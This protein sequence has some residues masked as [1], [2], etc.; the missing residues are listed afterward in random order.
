MVLNIMLNK[1]IRN[2]ITVHEEIFEAIAAHPKA[3]NTEIAKIVFNTKVGSNYSL[4]SLKNYVGK[5]RKAAKENIP[6]PTI[7]DFKY[8]HTISGKQNAVL[9]FADFP[10]ISKSALSTMLINKG[11]FTYGTANN[12]ASAVLKNPPKPKS[13]TKT[14]EKV[15]MVGGSPFTATQVINEAK[16]KT[17]TKKQSVNLLTEVIIIPKSQLSF[18]DA[19]F[20]DISRN[21]N[22][23]DTVIICVTD[24]RNEILWNGPRSGLALSRQYTN[25]NRYRKS[26]TT[27]ICWADAIS[28]CIYLASGVN[29][30]FTNIHC[31][32]ENLD[33]KSEISSKDLREAVNMYRDELSWIFSATTLGV[34]TMGKDQI[35][36]LIDSGFERASVIQF[37]DYMYSVRP[38]IVNL[39]ESQITAEGY[40][41]E[42]FS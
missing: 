28:Q 16:S 29:N 38:K 17:D 41:Y 9:A 6:A 25:S 3:N 8:N 34:T 10:N 24:V 30:P 12:Y 11:G 32:V 15:V 14:K 7:N 2:M 1:I 19:Y 27:N 42:L 4:G 33:R 37:S 21:G 13:P 40:L 20:R 26:A 18:M 36:A 31:I 5:A 35:K 23:Q 22:Q 39:T